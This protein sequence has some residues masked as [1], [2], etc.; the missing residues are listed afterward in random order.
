MSLGGLLF[1]GGKVGSG[2]DL[3]ESGGIMGELRGVERG[4]AAVRMYYVRRI[5][6]NK[7]EQGTNETKNCFF[8]KTTR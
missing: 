4:E 1:F 5:N 7:M 3:V 6:A 2:V 8:V